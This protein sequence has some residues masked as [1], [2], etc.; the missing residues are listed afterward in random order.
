MK[1]PFEILKNLGENIL[2]LILMMTIFTGCGN[3]QNI[4]ET[5]EVKT[6]ATVTA[7]VPAT[8]TIFLTPV[9]RHTQETGEPT[10]TL[11]LSPQKNITLVPEFHICSPLEEHG[12]YELAGIISSP[13]DPP[14]IGKDDRHQGIDFAYYNQN[15]RDSIEGEGVT[16]IMR[17][18][19]V[20]VLKEIKPYGNMVIIETSRDLLS[21]DIAK[22]VGILP[23]ESLYHLYAHLK[24]IPYPVAGEWIEC[25]ELIGEVGK[26]GYNIPVA[27]L[28]LETRIGPAEAVFK[29]MGYYDTRT[30]ELAR[31]NY[32]VWRMSGD[33]RHFD[34]M[35]L[36]SE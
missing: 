9:L 1:T 16:A 14:P 30:S 7:S 33:F 5:Q 32:E 4:M 23:G 8:A 31:K 20:T 22:N 35:M 17:G 19:L 6:S 21:R 27:H 26:S 12:I 15:G 25:G 13:Y 24:A 11:A 28:H 29:Q 36:F 10:I 34:P 2:L 18:K 3:Q